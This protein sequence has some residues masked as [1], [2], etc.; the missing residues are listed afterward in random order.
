[1]FDDFANRTEGFFDRFF[2]RT[3]DNNNGNNTFGNSSYRSVVPYGE[4]VERPRT[5]RPRAS[6]NSGLIEGTTQDVIN[7]FRQF[8]NDML[9]GSD[10]SRNNRTRGYNNSDRSNGNNNNN[11]DSFRN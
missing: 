1:M 7:N 6:N 5:R 9:N 3:D 11:F 8:F 4:D 2:N 10:R